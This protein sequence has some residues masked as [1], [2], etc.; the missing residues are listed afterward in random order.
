MPF[1]LHDGARIYWRAQ[2][3]PAR[4]PL[5]LLH[6]IGTDSTLWDRT[7]PALVDRFRLLRVDLRGHGA[8]DSP[9]GDYALAL[10]AQDVAAAMTAA[11]VGRAAV[12]GVSL[13]GMVAMQLALDR[14]DLVTALIPICTSAAMDAAVWDERIRTV[15]AHGV[16]AIADAAM[17]RFLS[18]AFAATH[19][20]LAAGLRAELLAT[21]AEGYAGAGAAIRDMALLPRLPRIAV[22]TLVL[23]GTHDRSTPAAGHADR[24]AALVPGAHL[25]LLDASHLAPVDNPGAVADALI[26][27]LADPGTQEAERALLDAGTVNRRRVLGDAWVDRSLAAATAF[28]A[29]FQAMIARTAWQ[30]VW[31]RPGLDDR[32]RRLLVIAMTASLGRWEEFR[33]HVRS[34]LDRGGFT[35]DELKET[36]MQIAVYAGVPAANTGFAEAGPIVAAHLAAQADAGV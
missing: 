27:F 26:R 16:A 14:P 6:A 8:S 18:P 10:L 25:S 24:I 21:S 19:P 28:D 7:V 34:G 36:L 31:G 17:G 30:E 35:V 32:T 15:R 9:G 1:A 4:P 3:E 2:G 33:L 20:A 29:D 11:G 23:A 22:P 13:G 5:V 12:A